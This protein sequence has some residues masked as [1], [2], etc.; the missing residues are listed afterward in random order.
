MAG[1]PVQTLRI[2]VT[3]NPAAG[4]RERIMNTW[5][6]A[7]VG[8]TPKGTAAGDFVN[9][10]LNA[11]YQT[12]DTQLS[13]ELTGA[14]PLVRCFDLIEPKPRQPFAEMSLTT[15]ACGTHRSQREAAVCLSYRAA[16][17]SGVTPKRRRGRIFLGPF[18]ANLVATATGKLDPTMKSALVGAAQT[19]LDAHQASALWSWVV[20]SPTT[21]VLGTGETGM[22]EVISAWIDDEIDIQRRRGLPQPGVKTVMT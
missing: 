20:Y 10:F 22:Y 19:L 3:L 21:D 8:A 4:S 5:H 6:I 2:E 15:L 14:V 18:N 16:Y 9:T 11:F 13:S 7:T 1:T 12:I 17:A